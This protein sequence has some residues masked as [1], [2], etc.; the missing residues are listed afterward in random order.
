MVI[1]AII[2]LMSTIAL[3]QLDV[4]KAKARDAMKIKS[5][6]EIQSALELY[7][8]D[9]GA[10]PQPKDSIGNDIIARNKADGSEKTMSNILQGIIEKGYLPAIPIPP[11]GS[12]IAGD[13]FYYQTVNNLEGYAYR[14]GTR[15]LGSA[16]GVPYI[17]YFTTER[18]QKLTQLYQNN[19]PVNI[20]GYYG[21]CLTLN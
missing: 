17:L 3:T 19:L 20:S 21:Y 2:A 12:S 5:M 7:Y 16:G 4:S 9:T 1:G 8:L 6:Q 15:T 18:P 13:A 14:C 11:E 10:Y